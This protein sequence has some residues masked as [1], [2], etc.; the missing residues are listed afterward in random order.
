MK[1]V[2][3]IIT[4]L[5]ITISC[6]KKSVPLGLRKTINQM[7]RNLNDTIKYDFKIAP[8]EVAGTKHH[9]GLGL[10]LRNGKGL[11]RGSLLKT[12]FRLNGI[13]HPDDMS[14][15]IL[16]TFHRRLNDKPIQFKKQKKHFKEFWKVSSIG[17][18]A[19]SIWWKKNHPEKQTDSLNQIY[20]S[21]FYKDR[22]VLGSVVA[23]K[24]RKNGASLI[25][26]KMIGQIIK[27]NDWKLKIKIIKLGKVEDG[28]ELW[29]KVNDTIESETDSV[30]LIPI[31]QE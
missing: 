16:T 2:L 17:E 18:D 10:D 22:L 9:F 11:W 19:K 1:K 29:E 6:S 8:E 27:R 24:K 13:W 7:E 12:Y 31:T 3:Y 15:I 14:S 5:L 4:I 23:L 21:Y 20:L 28:F 25:D 26:V 30:Y